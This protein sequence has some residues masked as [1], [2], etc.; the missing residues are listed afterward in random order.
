VALSG[1][2][3]ACHFERSEF[4]KNASQPFLPAKPLA[5][6]APAR[7]GKGPS[8][9]PS[10]ATTKPSSCDTPSSNPGSGPASW[11]SGVRPPSRP[12]AVLSV[13]FLH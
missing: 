10:A 1:S 13:W 11:K 5:V 7:V 9:L 12:P 3:R 8:P 2:V 6:R 4:T